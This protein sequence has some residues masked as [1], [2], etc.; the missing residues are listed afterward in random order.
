MQSLP[1]I[2]SSIEPIWHADPDLDTANRL[3]AD[4][5]ISRLGIEFTEIGDDHLAARMPVDS[6]TRTPLGIL[7][8]GASV[9]LAE[10]LVSWAA[11]FVTEPGRA[12][13]GM[14]INANHLRS[15]ASGWVT[16]TARPIAL[17]RRSQVWEVRIVDDDDRLVCVSRCTLAVMERS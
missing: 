14:E 11:T 13:V 16:G 1:D 9:L 6:R 3:S 15:V 17:G 5:A 2:T 7:H 8:G 12:C 4:S 10:T